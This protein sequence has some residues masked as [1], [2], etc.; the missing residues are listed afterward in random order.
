[1]R[2][3]NSAISFRY[4]GASTGDISVRVNG[5]QIHTGGSNGTD[6]VIAYGSMPDIPAVGEFF[7]FEFRV[8]S[9]TPILRIVEEYGSPSAVYAPSISHGSLTH[10][11]E[12][13]TAMVF[14]L[15]TAQAILQ[16][17]GWQYAVVD[18]PAGITHP[19]WSFRKTARYLH[20]KRNGST[21]AYIFDPAEVEDDVALTRT[22]DNFSTLDLDSIG[23]LVPNGLAY[24]WKC[25]SIWLDDRP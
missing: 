24:A 6:V 23:W 11:E 7:S 4:E 22:R 20:Y 10:D 8:N 12:A 2:R 18:R 14:T 13:F 3:K 15:N 9:G 21:T 1:M 5:E 25:D 17:A 19:Q 16:N